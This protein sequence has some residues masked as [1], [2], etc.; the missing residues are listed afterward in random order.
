[1]TLERLTQITS[2]GISS[3]IT[4]SSATLTGVTTLTTLS[5]GGDIDAVNGTFSGNVS[6]AGTL[7]Y[8]DVTN[9]DSV[10]LITARSGIHVTGGSVG[11]G[12]DNPQYKLEV[13]GATTPAIT[14]RNTTT[15]S[16]S[17]LSAG[18]I[19]DGEIFAF[20][21]LGST[22]SASGGPKAGQIWNYADAPIV[23]G[24]G[25]TV[26][27]KIQG[28]GKIVVGGNANQTANRNLSVVAESGNSNNTEIGLQ[29]TNS[30]GGYNPEVI[31][32]TTADGTYGAHMFF[33]TRDTGGTRT[34]RI[35]ITSNGLVGIGLTNP[36]A[37]L[38]IPA[39]E[40]N[41]PRFAIESAVDNNDFTITQYEDGNG[42]Y[43]MLGQNVKLNS[44]GNNTILDSGH[45]TAGI[46]LDARNHGAI[47]FLTGDTN[48][49]TE[50]VK[51]DASGNVTIPNIPLLKTN[52]G[53]VYGSSGSLTTS[54][55]PATA[56][57]QS[58]A[59][60]DRG[61]NG[62]TTTG[63]NAY[64]FVCPVTGIYAVHA[65][66]SLDDIA[67]GNRIIFTMAYTLGGG[68]LPLDS[69]VEVMDVNMDDYMNYSYYNTWNFT[70]GT[71]VGF[72]ING[73]SGTVSGIYGQWGIHLIA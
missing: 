69:Y 27:Q 54:P 68:N 7:T 10:G 52:A 66:M 48:A 42:T 24:I 20:Q 13:Q 18:E 23:M 47:T 19:G 2:V 49:V 35:R 29:P 21:R 17:R 58:A 4:L 53:N 25:S 51:I 3:G 71:R 43:T 6:I 57:L 22:S 65:H 73:T 61:N 40:S 31:I 55:L 60:I 37:L 1:M 12:T 38:S 64:T 39:G 34:E 44:S 67:Q 5:A 56:I 45:R 26:R 46:L 16:Y 14:V 32:G 8:E 63:S 62:W 15:S 70:A 30:S 41:T 28:D 59:E 36:G 33:T 72:G 11:I 9:I 50:N